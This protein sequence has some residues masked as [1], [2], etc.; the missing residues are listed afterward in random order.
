MD[1]ILSHNYE[2]WSGAVCFGYSPM[3]YHKGPA[4]LE[5]EQ[6]EVALRMPEICLIGLDL[7]KLLPWKAQVEY[8][9]NKIIH[10]VG[11]DYC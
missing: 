4:L 1:K 11:L 2:F 8:E 3:A 5:F 7:K 9:L 10:G 6:N